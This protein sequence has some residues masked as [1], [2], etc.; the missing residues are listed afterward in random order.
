M[1]KRRTNDMRK[2]QHQEIRA[3]LKVLRLGYPDATI[4]YSF[5]AC[6]AVYQL[7]KHLYPSAVAYFDD[8][9]KSHILSK[10]GGKYYDITGEFDES[11]YENH[12]P[13]QLTERD[14]EIWEGKSGIQRV[15]YMLSKYTRANVKRA[16]GK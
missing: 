16:E 11:Q 12:K 3:L 15:E 14:L 13:V 10:I 4:I 8:D 7:L 6:F 9:E 1:W 5:G 2:D